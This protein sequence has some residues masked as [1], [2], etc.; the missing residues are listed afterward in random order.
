MRGFQAAGRRE[1]GGSG[2]GQSTRQGR[3]YAMVFVGLDIRGYILAG[4]V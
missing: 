2:G 1:E 3:R 4:N